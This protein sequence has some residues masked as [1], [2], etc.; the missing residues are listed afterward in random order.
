MILDPLG[1]PLRRRI[2]FLREY[3]AESNEWKHLG[4]AQPVELVSHHRIRVPDTKA[5]EC[6]K[7]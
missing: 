5:D 2:G 4:E 1:R 6:K 3:E 7:K